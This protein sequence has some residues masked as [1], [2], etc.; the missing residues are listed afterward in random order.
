MRRPS[1]R[2]WRVFVIEEHEL[3][4]TQAAEMLDLQKSCFQD[5]PPEELDEDFDRPSIARVL[6]YEDVALVGC[7]QVF[8]RFVDY[9]GSRIDLGG[10]GG[11]CTRADR[12]R[13]GIGTRVCL[14]AMSYLRERRCEIAFLA[15]GT[16]TG[17]H[18]FYEP[19]GFRLL[20]RPF[21]YANSQ[22]LLKQADGGMIAPLCSPDVY[23]QVMKGETAFAL[24]PERGYW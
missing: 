23:E 10:F 2:E 11:V 6:A 3:S 14:A 17:T 18:R 1:G 22:G 7:A 5:I 4:S 16:S 12:R 20:A 24:T 8:R 19:F 9:R 13:Q 21:V 15:V